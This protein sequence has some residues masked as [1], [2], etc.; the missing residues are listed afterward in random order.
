[1]GGNSFATSNA[2]EINLGEKL[3]L[4]AHWVKRHRELHP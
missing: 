2:D 3:V 4:A 1:M